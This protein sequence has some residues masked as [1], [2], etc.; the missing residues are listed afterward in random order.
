MI[1]LSKEGEVTSQPQFDKADYTS[2]HSLFTFSIRRYI[3][4]DLVF[5]IVWVDPDKDLLLPVVEDHIFIDHE[6]PI[7]RC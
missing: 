3:Y 1:S 7:N 6:K 5:E 2:N 4:F